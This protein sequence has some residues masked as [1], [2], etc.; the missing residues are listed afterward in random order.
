MEKLQLCIYFFP[1]FILGGETAGIIYFTVQSKRWGSYFS[2]YRMGEDAR[3]GG[4]IF[5]IPF[6]VKPPLS[7]FH[8]TIQQNHCDPPE[9]LYSDTL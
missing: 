3:R 8:T 6:A 2:T 1:L 7:F 9:V 4:I 5:V